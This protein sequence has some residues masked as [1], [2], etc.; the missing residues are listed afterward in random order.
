MEQ[1]VEFITINNIL[2][3]PI[4]N[5]PDNSLQLWIENTQIEHPFTHIKNISVNN[6]VCYN[7]FYKNFF[8]KVLEKIKIQF[9]FKDFFYKDSDLLT[10]YDK[11]QEKYKNIDILILNSQPF[12][13]QYNYNKDEWDRYICNLNKKYNIVTT[14]KVNNDIKC[15]ADD[16]LTIKTIAAISIKV[17]V[18]IAV[19]SGVVPGL[20]N[21]YTLTNVKQF[22][23]FDDRCY[24]SY[25]NFTS[26][27]KIT[28]I[29]F[30]ELSNFIIQKIEEPKILESKI[31]EP[32]IQINDKHKDFDW[33]VYIQF[34]P[35]LSID[36]KLSNAKTLAWKHFIENGQY[37]NRVHQLDWIKY[38]ND[39]NLSLHI[40][41]KEELLD[42]ISNKN[43][44]IVNNDNNFKYKLFDWE[45]YVNKYNDLSHIN[46]YSDALKHYINHGE[47]ENRQMSNFNWMD[48]LLL[49]RDL[50]EHNINTESKAIEHWINHGKNENRKYKI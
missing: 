33:E 1:L 35:D 34:N 20:L 50:I 49:N 31:E 38:I 4:N 12:S 19:N 24:Y 6:R 21:Y 27:E 45:F 47:N 43:E 17:S 25:P 8:N 3:F 28:N 41:N 40:K 26:R 15:T 48:Y 32:K 18:I 7:I 9:R 42:Y 11:L 22:Y 16:N 36:K 37:E 30:G 39:N 5:K 29:T 13:E 2:L 14:T 44:N 23:T 46:N 10:R